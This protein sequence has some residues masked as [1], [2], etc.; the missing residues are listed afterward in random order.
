MPDG[1]PC[2]PE[3]AP[4]PDCGKH[5]LMALCAATALPTLPAPAWEFP[6]MLA[7]SKLAA[8]HDPA[9]SGIPPTPPPKPPRA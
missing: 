7:S 8:R 5:C 3:K 9:L 1:M 2:C 6:L 4:M